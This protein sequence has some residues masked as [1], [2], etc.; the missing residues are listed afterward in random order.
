MRMGIGIGW[1]NASAS[2][3]SQMVYF[4]IEEVCGEGPSIWVKTTQ[5]VDS[6]VYQTGDYVDFDNGPEGETGRVLLDRPIANPGEII[7]NIY[8]PVYTSCPV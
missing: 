1:P 8:G 3:Q 2:N 7:Y 4:G 5:L 6:S